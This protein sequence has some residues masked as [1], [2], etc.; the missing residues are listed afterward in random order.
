MN[1]KELYREILGV[2]ELWRIKSIDLKVEDGRVDIYIEWPYG[3]DG[4][5]PEC[6]ETYKIHDR[7]EERVWRHLDTCQLKTFIHCQIPRVKCPDHKTKTMKVP[8]AEDMSRF[9]LQFE[10]IAI[11]FLEGSE[12]R[13]KTAEALRISWDEMNNIMNKAVRRGLSRRDHE[14]I[15]YIGMDEKSFL[16]GHNYIS[17]MTDTVGKRVLDVTK[18]RKKESVDKLWGSLTEEQKKNVEAVS[19]DFWKAYITGAQNHVPNAAI[20]HDKFHIIKYMNEAV[21]KVRKDENKRLMSQDIKTLIGTKYIWLKNK[22]NFTKKNK[23]DFK[24]LSENQLAVGRAWNRKELLKHLWDYKYEGAARTYFKKWYFSAT[25]S[26]LKPIIDVAKMFK[27][28]IENI[29]TYIKHR[30]TNA[31]AEGINSK[32]QHIKATARG[33]RNFDN[34]RISI[35]FYCGKL[36]LYP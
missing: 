21:D 3:E 18:D 27:R 25:H 6:G 1:D 17:V 34:Y 14:T 19:M 29:F 23:R 11:Q 16:K 4:I 9:T 7:R 10:R 5:C 8:W 28:H 32:I 2:G 13:S 24:I 26:R 12:N 36:S 35:L 33:F 31:Y 15:K 30:I 20:V 22:S